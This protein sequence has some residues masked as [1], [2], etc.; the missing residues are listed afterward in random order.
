MYIYIFIY[1]KICTYIYV[2]LY[3]HIC[4]YIYIHIYTHLHILYLYIYTCYSK[5]WDLKIKS[6]ASSVNKSV[7]IHVF[8]FFLIMFWIQAPFSSLVQTI[9]TKTWSQFHVL[10]LLLSNLLGWACGRLGRVAGGICIVAAEAAPRY[11]RRVGPP[12]GICSC[13]EH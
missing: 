5:L 11:L 2:H 6:F 7:H 10:M 3:I 1:T 8:R 4:I 13:C 9:D 12:L